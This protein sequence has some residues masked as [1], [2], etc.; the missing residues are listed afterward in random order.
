[1]CN[2][3]NERDR[4]QLTEFLYR[5]DIDHRVTHTELQCRIHHTRHDKWEYGF[6]NYS[7]DTSPR[8]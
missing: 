4:L 3:T 8:L 2:D 5:V 1:M 6:I 7:P